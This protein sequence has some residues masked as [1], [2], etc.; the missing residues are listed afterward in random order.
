MADSLSMM[1]RRSSRPA[2]NQAEDVTAYHEGRYA[3]HLVL[4]H[5]PVPSWAWVNAITHGNALLIA[6]LALAESAP[7]GTPEPLCYW[8]E[9]RKAMAEELMRVV[10]ETR[11]PVE[12]VQQE[13]LL[14][15]ELE[16]AASGDWY[17]RGPLETACAVFDALAAYCDEAESI[18]GSGDGAE[19]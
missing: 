16:L 7:A 12:Q 3:D 8:Y 1:G 13:V 19:D 11:C 6:S 17:V 15:L 10:T 5:R 2:A 14:G 18:D 4:H 9:A